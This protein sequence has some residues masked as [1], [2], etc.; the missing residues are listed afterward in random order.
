MSINY[1]NCSFIKMTNLFFLFNFNAWPN[2]NALNYQQMLF[3]T[4]VP[5]NIHVVKFQYVFLF[6]WE[7]EDNPKMVSNKSFIFR[8]LC[9]HLA[10]QFVFWSRSA[11]ASRSLFK[12]AHLVPFSV[13]SLIVRSLLP[14]HSPFMLESRTF[15]KL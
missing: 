9:V 8:S 4:F 1:V 14:V 12:T 11:Y 3:Q 15:Q 5:I 2:F 10:L 6:K 13:R 7:S